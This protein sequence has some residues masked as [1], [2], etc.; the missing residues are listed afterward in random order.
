LT[1]AHTVA[2]FHRLFIDIGRAEVV[3]SD[4]DSSIATL[5]VFT[6]QDTLHLRVTLLDGYSRSAAYQK[7][8]VAGL[9]LQV[10]LGRKVGNASDIYSDQFTWVA[11]D[12]LADPYFAAALPMSTDAIATLLA[13]AA[14]APAFFEVKLLDGGLPRTVLSKQVTVNAAVIKDGALEAVAVPTPI[15]AEACNALFLQRTNEA[16]AGNPLILRNGSITMALY[17]DAAGVFQTVRLT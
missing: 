9:T 3:A 1:I 13:A 15:S 2:S 17:V 4:T 12:D 7:V 11:S 16:T 8:A 6:Q 10:A 14:S 5:P